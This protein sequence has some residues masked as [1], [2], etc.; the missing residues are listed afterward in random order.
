MYVSSFCLLLQ[1][2]S[3]WSSASALRAAVTLRKLGDNL[4]SDF[5]LGAYVPLLYDLHVDH[6]VEL[7][8]KNG[9]LGVAARSCITHPQYYCS[10]WLAVDTSGNA[11]LRWDSSTVQGD[12]LKTTS[13]GFVLPNHW[14]VPVKEIRGLV[15]PVVTGSTNVTVEIQFCTLKARCAEVISSSPLVLEVTRRKLFVNQIIPLVKIVL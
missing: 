7:R 11:V 5:P 14:H 6:Q 12:F 8:E 9:L 2:V 4:T 13:H 15:R 3:L 10:D 1:F